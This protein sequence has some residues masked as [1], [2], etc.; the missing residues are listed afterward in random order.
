LQIIISACLARAGPVS[1]INAVPGTKTST[2]MTTARRWRL[3]A[4]TPPTTMMARR[5]PAQS[6]RTVAIVSALA[7]PLATIAVTIAMAR[8]G[9]NGSTAL[10]LDRSAPTHGLTVP[11]R[12]LTAVK[13]NRTERKF[14]PSVR[15][16]DPSVPHRVVAQIRFM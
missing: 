3:T 4:R 6:A 2:M 15:S 16:H 13:R 5:H 7:D 8:R 12:G 9:P 10:K 1:K 14:D 11:R